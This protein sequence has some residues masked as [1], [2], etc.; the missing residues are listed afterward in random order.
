MKLFAVGTEA[1]GVIAIGQSATGVIAIGQLAFGVVA[2]ASWARGVVVVGQLTVG[3][4][5]LGQLAVGLGWSAGM[6][7]IAP[8]TPG[9]PSSPALLGRLSL[10]DLVRGRWRAVERRPVRVWAVALSVVVAALVIAVTLVPLVHELTRVGGVF[11]EAPA[12]GL[13]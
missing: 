13:R 9:W 10:G 12:P 6:L 5:C 4:V 1:V 7:G 2:I 8:V 3:V 11:R